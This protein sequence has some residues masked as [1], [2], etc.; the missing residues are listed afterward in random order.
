MASLAGFPAIRDYVT[1]LF[2]HGRKSE[3]TQLGSMASPESQYD[4]YEIFEEMILSNPAAFASE[5]G[6][7]WM[8]TTYAKY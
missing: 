7:Q 3:Q 5:F 8:Y 1:A 2:N 4:R 6:M